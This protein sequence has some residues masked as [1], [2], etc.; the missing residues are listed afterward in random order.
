MNDIA[1][2]YYPDRSTQIIITI[3]VMLVAIIEVLDMTIVNVALPPMMGALGANSDEITW[4]LTAYIVSSAIVMPLTGLLVKLVGRRTLLMINITGFMITSLLCGLS[5]SLTEMVFL[6]TL[7][8]IFG[9]SLIPLSQYILRD[10]YPPKEHGHAMAIWGVG[11]MVAPVLGPTLGGYITSWL[12][13]RWIFFINVPVCIVAFSLTLFNITETAREYIRIDWYGLALMVIGIGCLQIV[14]DRGNTSGW[15]SSNF[16][17]IM[18]IAAAIGLLTFIHKGVH[19][20]ENIINLMLFRYRNFWL[21]CTILLI[22]SM[23]I[24]GMISVQPILLENLFNYNAQTAGLAMAPRALASALTMIAAGFLTDKIDN[25]W[26]IFTGVGLTAIGSYLTAHIN[27]HTSFDLF[28]WYGFI[29][30][31]GMG[32]VFTPLSTLALSE[33]A[34]KEMAEGAGLFSFSRSI[35]SSI[36]ISILSTTISRETQ[37]NWHQLGGHLVTT[38]YNFQRWLQLKGMSI[39]NPQDVHQ[40]AQKLHQ[41]ATMVAFV[42][43]FWLV[44]LSSALLL[45]FVFFLKRAPHN[46]QGNMP[47]H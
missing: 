1:N 5:V 27:L 29:Q 6:R 18:S 40:I 7:Q 41:Q 11:I 28:A 23:G 19:D 16:I 8:G 37:V 3:S 44:T 32:L 10:T 15:F 22:Y 4:V 20:K 36:G 21:C 24:I 42:D 13:W 43:T 26:M 38:Q 9:A 31:L 47:N 39:H 30:G 34:G 12:N 35:G 14:L 46:P 45:P 17:L 25:R 33:M 2:K